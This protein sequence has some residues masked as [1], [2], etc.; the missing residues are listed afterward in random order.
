MDGA[1]DMDGTAMVPAAVRPGA[2]EMGWDG[3][4]AGSQS[5]GS[6]RVRF[7]SQAFDAAADV[8]SV[9]ENLW[10]EKKFGVADPIDF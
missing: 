1:V 2:W 7:E 8:Q 6:R 5:A 9:F 10:R 3:T 4:A